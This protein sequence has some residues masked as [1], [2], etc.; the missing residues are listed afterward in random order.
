VNNA[1]QFEHAPF[2]DSEKREEIK[3]RFRE[4]LER[5]ISRRRDLRERVESARKIY[6]EVVLKEFKDTEVRA[7]LN[8]LFR[9]KFEVEF[10]NCMVRSVFKPDLDAVPAFTAELV[11][12]GESPFRFRGRKNAKGAYEPVCS[13]YGWERAEIAWIMG[14]SESALSRRL[15]KIARLWPEEYKGIV[16]KHQHEGIKA[17]A[18]Y[19][20]RVFDLL[21]EF[22]KEDFMGRFVRKPF[23][24]SSGRTAKDKERAMEELRDLWDEVEEERNQDLAMQN[25]LMNLVF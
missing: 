11:I 2:L 4:E 14:I 5:F 7:A 3:A 13:K 21:L 22:E 10:K 8:D 1:L 9:G 15:D 16:L 17:S 18:V 6:E 12:N 24:E 23:S 25:S 19:H 20:E